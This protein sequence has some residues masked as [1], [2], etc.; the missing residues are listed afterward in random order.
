MT[1][2]IRAV[3][4]KEFRD[5]RRNRAILSTM[6][7][8][9]ALLLATS[10][11][12]LLMLPDD[13]PEAPARII[14]PFFLVAFMY[15]KVGMPITIAAHS[16]IGERDQRSLEPLL[17][18]PI[19]DRELLWGKALAAGLPA[20]V[21]ICGAY[22][23]FLLLVYIGA[24]PAIAELIASA[25]LVAAVMAVTPVIVAYAVV[26]AMLISARSSDARAAQQSAIRSTL[27]VIGLATLF[28]Y[29]VIDST[30]LWAVAG[31]GLVAAVDLLGWHLLVRLF[32]RERLLTRH[33]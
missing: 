11:V 26:A 21:T 9:P 2:R 7:W 17:A 22:G 15:L 6:L 27:P 23:I 14:A 29:G 8:A 13:L 12:I 24:P 33:R 30:P 19:S 28:A 18:S 4:R 10:A 5:Y 16:I 1:P 25:A 31:A 20:I 3:I 32:N